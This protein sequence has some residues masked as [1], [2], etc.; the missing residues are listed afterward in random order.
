MWDRYT[1]I[2]KIRESADRFGTDNPQQ[3]KQLTFAC[4][5]SSDSE[6]FFG[7]FSFF[8]NPSLQENTYAHIS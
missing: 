2:E 1:I 3:I 7:L 6:L 5:K 8:F 4:E